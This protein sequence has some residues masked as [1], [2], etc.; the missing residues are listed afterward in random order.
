MFS[1][2][3][4]KLEPTAANHFKL[5]YY[6]A[7]LHAVEQLVRSLGS[8]ESVLERFP[9]LTVYYEEL[10]GQG[11]SD[12]GSRVASET[13]LSAIRDWEKNFSGHL[14]L[15][16]LSEECGLNSSALLMV[17]LAGLPEEDSRFGYVFEA[18]HGVD[19]QP[20]LT[21]AL[22]QAW[23]GGA[24][25]GRGKLRRLQELGLLRAATAGSS[26]GSGGVQVPPVLW[27]VMHAE[28]AERPTD[29]AAWRKCEEL[30]D[31][32]TLILPEATKQKFRS[33]SKLMTKKNISCVVVRGPRHNGRGTLLGAIAREM[34]RGLLEFRG[35][36]KAEDDRWKHIGV[37]C[38]LLHAMPAL[39]LELGP[40]ETQEIPSLN[41]CQSPVGVVLERS[42]ALSGGVMGHS[43][44]FS[45]PIPDAGQREQI[46]NAAL[47][48][49]GFTI[50]LEV[51]TAAE[52]LRLTTGSI[53][54]VVRFAASQAELEE[55]TEIL[56]GDLRIAVS[57]LHH[58]AMETLAH[59][60]RTFGDWEQ[61]AVATQTHE[62]LRALE[63]RCLYRER[64]SEGIHP[65]FG[66]SLSVGVRAMF[67]GASGTGKT[68]AAQVLAARLKKALYRLDLST[69]VNKYI[70][71]T[72]KNLS[73]VFARAEELDVVLLL[74]EG[75]ALLT[76]RTA[77]QTSNDRFANLETN[78][79]LQ[80]LETFEGILIVT[81]NA[82][83]RID[84]AFQRRMDVVIDF[85][86]PEATERWGIWQLHLPS[87]HRVDETFLTEVAGRCVMTGGQ[88]RNATLHASVLALE[89]GEAMSAAHLEVA[90]QREYRKIGAV[91]P[92]RPSIAPGISRMRS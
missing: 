67:S 59:E 86:P 21:I 55:R 16:A 32:E 68:L 53:G 45:L 83:D 89:H 11:L 35:P 37:L 52:R 72:E 8:I 20:A 22:L 92:L 81:T 10:A 64:L 57:E 2:P 79:L 80:R 23:F 14:P 24:E 29:W 54:R 74:D 56:A 82:A 58:H 84:R 5:Y 38:T 15:R 51:R 47:Q 70:G 60:V 90:V 87:V 46:W 50:G 1:K 65:A 40:G 49:E 39:R 44:T 7:V 6:A 76:Q 41:G 28:L 36:I 42:G 19:G 77:V 91:C 25:L 18:A 62:E 43:I 3:F 88:I 78:Y 66:T 26:T 69:V 75:D 13:W 30:P 33:L 12:I 31:F 9:F 48:A 34:G 4:S 61:L 85:R 63:S 27:D 73:R 17:L 71:E